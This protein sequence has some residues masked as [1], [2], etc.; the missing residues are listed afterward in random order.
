MIVSE[1]I[2]KL[3]ELPEE[4]EVFTYDS[5]H[6]Y[7]Y[8]PEIVIREELTVWWREGEPKVTAVVIM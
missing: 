4:L 7:D 6:G 5:E 8:N 2:E 3:H 1:L